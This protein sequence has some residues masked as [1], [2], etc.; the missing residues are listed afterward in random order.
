MP[1]RGGIRRTTRLSGPLHVNYRVYSRQ[2][3]EEQLADRNLLILRPV[4]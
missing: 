1:P 4:G 3:L 2:R